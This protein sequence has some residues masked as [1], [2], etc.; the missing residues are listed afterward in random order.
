MVHVAETDSIFS[1]AG[2]WYVHVCHANRYHIDILKLSGTGIVWYQI[3]AP[4]RT[5]FFCF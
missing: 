4:I 5:L 1:G 2:F 3:P